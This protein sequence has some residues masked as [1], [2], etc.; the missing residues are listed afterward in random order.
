MLCPG[1]GKPSSA[2]L[3][4]NTFHALRL[5]GIRRS[6]DEAVTSKCR[7][8]SLGTMVTGRET[9]A[10]RACFLGV[11]VKESCAEDSSCEIRGNR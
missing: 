4:A 2:H 8:L 9:R 7:A 11:Y 10:V 3:L 5:L 1:S 6:V